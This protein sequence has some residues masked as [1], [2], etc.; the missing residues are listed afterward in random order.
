MNGLELKT[1]SIAVYQKGDGV[2]PH[3]HEFYQMYHTI[4]GVASMMIG[5]TA[6]E[7]RPDMVIMISPGEMHSLFGVGDT[8]VRLL[9]VQF[10]LRDSVVCSCLAE[11]GYANTVDKDLI[12][13]LWRV[14]DEWNEEH[15]LSEEMAGNIFGQ[16]LIEYLRYC[17][18]SDMSEGVN[19]LEQVDP[20]Q[21]V[22]VSRLVVDY[23]AQNY[24]GEIS[25]QKM[26]EDLSYSKNYLCRAFKQSTG[27]TIVGYINRV[28]IKKAVQQIRSTDKKLSEIF[29]MI[30]F[31]D[32]HYFFRVF[33]AVTGY[34]PGELRN[35]EKFT[36]Y[37]ENQGAQQIQY[38]YF[39]EH[40]NKR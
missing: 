3:R 26:A 33:K 17:R 36:I 27:Y 11:A 13:T 23:I 30:G 29:R 6:V 40:E 2:R 25:L 12:D 35:K 19:D 8:A 16:Y 38:R 7:V 5:E 9:N 39:G 14:K 10:T 28:R 22:G 24:A 4:S 18:T 37:M 15:F 34:T 21:L 31:S 32:F 20:E 1:V